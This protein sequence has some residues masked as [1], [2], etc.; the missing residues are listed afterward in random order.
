[1]YAQVEKQKENTSSADRRKSRATSNSV[2]QKRSNRKQGFGFV[3]YRPE[4]VAQRKLQEMA[5]THSAQQQKPIQKK[6]SPELSRREKNTGLPDNL[7]AGILQSNNDDPI[8]LKTSIEY[9]PQTLTFNGKNE[10]IGESMKAHLD[11]KDPI[12]G[13]KTNSKEIPLIMNYLNNNFSNRLG[14]WHRGHML[15]AKLGGLNI[16]MNLVPIPESMNTGSHS[17]VEGVAKRL[18]RVGVHSIY[19]VKYTI[20]PEQ[21]KITINL[22]AKIT[23]NPQDSSEQHELDIREGLDGM[24]VKMSSTILGDTVSYKPSSPQP[25]LNYSMDNRPLISGSKYSKYDDDRIEDQGWGMLKNP[26]S[27]EVALNQQDVTSVNNAIE[28]NNSLGNTFVVDREILSK[29]KKYQE[30]VEADWRQKPYDRYSNFVKCWDYKLGS[31]VYKVWDSVGYRETF[32]KVI[33]NSVTDDLGPDFRPEPRYFTIKKEKVN[34]DR[35]AVWLNCD[36]YYNDSMTYLLVAYDNK[37]IIKDLGANW[38]AY[39]FELIQTNSDNTK[40]YKRTDSYD[41]SITHFLVKSDDKTIIKDLGANWTAYTFELIR[42][43]L[44]G[45]EVYKRIDSYNGSITH[46]LVKSDDKTILKDLGTN[47]TDDSIDQN[48]LLD[49]QF[50]G[51]GNGDDLLLG[52][53]SDDDQFLGFGFWE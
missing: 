30:R 10:Q 17:D 51:F 33:S 42:T 50:L 4:A 25:T 22:Y 26:S 52:F 41:S 39:T 20:Q 45:T 53:G 13:A 8:Q 29:S 31:E 5:N 32:V 47:W 9:K 46:L 48:S 21:S 7:K 1:M 12:K 23:P 6:A 15:N 16:N 3:D 14:G 24:N 40:I 34:Q 2:D 35:T 38:T 27:N 37:T 43:N 44:D 11:P 36:K 28:N 49:D 19:E 18:T